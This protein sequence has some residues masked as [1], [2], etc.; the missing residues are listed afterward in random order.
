MS[1]QG[2]SDIGS[3]FGD[4]YVGTDPEDMARQSPMA[5]VH[6]VRTPTLV[7]HSELDFRCPSSRRRV[8]TQR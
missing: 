1:F 7:L 4:E 8:T 5:V 3:F 6:D 2:T